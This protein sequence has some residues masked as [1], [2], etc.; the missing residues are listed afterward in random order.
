[1][2]KIEHGDSVWTMTIK[3]MWMLYI[4]KLEKGAGKGLVKYGK[5]IKVFI[6][7]R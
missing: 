3:E 7:G 1:M 6:E 4:V 2:D 5:Q